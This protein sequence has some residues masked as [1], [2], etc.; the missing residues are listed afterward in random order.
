MPNAAEDLRRHQAASELVPNSR[1]AQAVSGLHITTTDH[2]LLDHVAPVLPPIDTHNNV[3]LKS[4]I[5]K[6]CKTVKT[7]KTVKARTTRSRRRCRLEEI[8]DP[9]LP[10]R[11]EWS[12]TTAP[13]SRVLV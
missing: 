11:Y 8:A 9:R 1:I 2:G 4:G 13:L 10:E 7:V 3:E 6:I 12:D 5:L